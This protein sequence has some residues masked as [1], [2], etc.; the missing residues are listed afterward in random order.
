MG[1]YL[2]KTKLE[3][4][5]WQI[6]NQARDHVFICD[7]DKRS[8]E[9]AGPNPVEYLCGSINSCITMS[10]GMITKVHQLDVKNFHVENYAKTE[11]LGHGKS[12]VTELKIKVSFDSSMNREE[13]EKFIAHA[14]HISTVYQTLKEA[15]KIYVE[16]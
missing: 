15:I 11:N 7:A 6:A 16:F 9:D 12:V 14:L 3:N 8:K 5:E 4:T 2:V 10:A 1:D 13:K